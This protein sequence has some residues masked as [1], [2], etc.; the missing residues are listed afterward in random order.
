MGLLWEARFLLV[1]HA[2]MR[3]ATM[4]PLASDEAEV[5]EAPVLEE[6]ASAASGVDGDW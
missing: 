5:V 2:A 6:D 4:A 1:L 3:E